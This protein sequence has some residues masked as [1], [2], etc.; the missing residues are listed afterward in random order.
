MIRMK[1]AALASAVGLALG[2]GALAPAANAS[3]LTISTMTATG[4]S[5]GMG[6]FTSNGFLPI[7][8]FG[9]GAANIANQYNPPGW[10]VNNA[11]TAPA[12]SAIASF[13]FGNVG[14]TTVPNYVNTFTENTDPQNVDGGGHPVPTGTFDPV[15]G[16]ISLN[17]SSFY[18]NWNGTDFNQGSPTVSG[19]VTGCSGNTC[20]YNIAWFST[21]V[22]GPFNGNTGSWKLSGTVTG[23]AA[24]VPIPAAAWL[25]GSGLVGLVGIARRKRSNG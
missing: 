22:G 8:A 16:T 13:Q 11:Q 10:N 19:T 6:F 12:P 1:K 20:S 21:I 23:T 4:G 9:T 18:A 25:F 15:A 2:C 24:P 5:F 7:T 17:L 14:T 3:T